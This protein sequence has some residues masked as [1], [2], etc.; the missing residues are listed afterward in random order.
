[1][2]TI[3]DVSPALRTALTPEERTMVSGMVES[4]QPVTRRISGIRN[5]GAAIAPRVSYPLKAITAPTL[6]VHAA[7]DGINPVRVG[8]YT[9]AH[10]R[11]AQFLRIATGGH[12]LLGHHAE[13]RA[14][15]SAFLRQHAAG[16][17]R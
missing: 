5:E 10:I 14:R 3:F 8:E 1:L 17:G 15:V 16:A 11:G 7:D 13:V 6:I 9:A 4:F 2:E 12:L